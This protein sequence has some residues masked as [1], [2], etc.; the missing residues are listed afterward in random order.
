MAVAPH[1]QRLRLLSSADAQVASQLIRDDQCFKSGV[2]PSTSAVSLHL[3]GATVDQLR[4]VAFQQL[5]L[6]VRIICG[7]RGPLERL[8]TGLCG[9]SKRLQIASLGLTDSPGVTGPSPA[10]KGRE[11]R[12]YLDT[13]CLNSDT[14]VARHGGRRGRPSGR[15][16]SE[17]NGIW[18]GE[19]WHWCV[20]LL[21]RAAKQHRS[22]SCS[23]RDGRKQTAPWEHRPAVFSAQPNKGDAVAQHTV[24]VFFSPA[25]PGQ[26]ISAGR[27]SA[28]SL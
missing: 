27:D 14:G 5:R 15:P 22:C 3:C 24:V 16:A 20:T 12:R 17:G 10:E 13:L 4:M 25:S 28:R 11:E 26:R 7:P 6:A 1:C 21:W 9:E 19:A 8:A 23:A 18:Q 2:K